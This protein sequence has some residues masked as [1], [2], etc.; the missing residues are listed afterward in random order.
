MLNILSTHGNLK[1]DIIHKKYF[2][3]ATLCY[4]NRKNDLDTVVMCFSLGR[5]KTGRFEKW[6]IFHNLLHHLQLNKHAAISKLMD[7]IGSIEKVQ[8]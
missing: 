7:L 2:N 4:K 3:K 6:T 8:T 1:G 5:K